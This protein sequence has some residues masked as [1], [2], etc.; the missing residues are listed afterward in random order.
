[1]TN[2]ENT[3][4]GLVLLQSIVYEYDNLILAKKTKIKIIDKIFESSSQIIQFFQTILQKS[5]QQDIIESTLKVLAA[6]ADFKL[7]IL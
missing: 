7:Q 6:W 1:M 5:Q 3:R 2:L 4:G